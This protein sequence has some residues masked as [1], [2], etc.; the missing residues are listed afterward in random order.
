MPIEEYS[1][2]CRSILGRSVSPEEYN[3][4]IKAGTAASEAQVR[5]HS[6]YKRVFSF[7]FSFFVDSYC[8]IW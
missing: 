8:G 4:R 5:S 6:T 3:I 7:N 2:L 1:E